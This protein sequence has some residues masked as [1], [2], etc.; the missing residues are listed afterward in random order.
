MVNK[1][2]RNESLKDSFINATQGILYALRTQKNM[3]IHLW[4]A[5]T[6]LLISLGLQI[7][8]LQ[9][10]LVL[11]SV[12][13]V[14]CMELINTA[15]EKAVDLVTTDYHP[16]AKIAKDVAAGAVLFA[17]IFAFVTGL[18]IFIPHILELFSIQFTF[19]YEDLMVILILFLLIILWLFRRKG[20][21]K[22]H[23]K[24]DT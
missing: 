14:I 18:V 3:M 15:V 5:V 6:V 11:L 4:V 1:K 20:N 8:K 21:D 12:S 17:A 24:K 2:L 23:G 9:V 13:W 22:L 16:I 10:L 19:P 7:P